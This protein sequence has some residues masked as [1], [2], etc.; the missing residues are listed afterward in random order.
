MTYVNIAYAAGDK[1][2]GYI[3]SMA[4]DNDRYGAAPLWLS[5][6]PLVPITNLTI[7]QKINRGL[8]LL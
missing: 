4:F 7:I 5:R 2:R 8:H 6:P 1:F 3:S